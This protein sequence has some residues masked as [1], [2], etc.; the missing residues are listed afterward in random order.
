MVAVEIIM[1]TKIIAVSMYFD[2]ENHIEQDLEKMD[3]VLQHA[4][5]SGVFFASDSNAR[6]KLWHD[7]LTNTRGRILEEYIT[8]KQSYI[9]NEESSY[10]TFRN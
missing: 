4:K 7:N 2:R 10:T 8:S 6:S 5:D 1:G 3:L 9:V